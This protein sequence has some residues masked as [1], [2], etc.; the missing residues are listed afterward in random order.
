MPLSVCLCVCGVDAVPGTV[1]GTGDTETMKYGPYPEELSHLILCSALYGVAYT[2][3]VTSQGGFY[4]Q[5]A[6]AS[7]NPVVL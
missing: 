7:P 1:L 5:H 3:L 2:F 6:E 4:F